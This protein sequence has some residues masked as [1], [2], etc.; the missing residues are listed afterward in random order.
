M[1]KPEPTHTGA[2]SVAF[3]QSLGRHI[4]ER[5]VLQLEKSWR[6]AHQ[7]TLEALPDGTTVVINLATGDFATGAT[8]TEAQAAYDQTIGESSEHRFSFTKGRPIFVGGGL[9]RV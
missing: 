9:W 5:D 8:W 1:S 4:D 2:P 6:D 3:S 7:E